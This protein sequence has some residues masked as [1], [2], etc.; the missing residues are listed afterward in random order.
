[1]NR[2][3]EPDDARAP[4]G[5][6]RTLLAGFR[7]GAPEALRE[8]YRMHA[9]EITTM[10]RHGFAFESNA[11][12][13]RFGGLSSPFELQDALH[14]TFARA[15]E[16]AARRAFDGIRPYGPYLRT[17]A[18]NV[19]LRAGRRQRE[20]VPLPDGIEQERAVAGTDDDAGDPERAAQDR[21]LVAVVRAFLDRVAPA[22]R[23]LLQA[24]FVDGLSQRD[25]AEQLGL[26]RQQLRTR[27]ARLREA[28]LDHLRER[29]REGLAAVL[30]SLLTALVVEALR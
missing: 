11:G 21:E 4:C 6:S 26:G 2:T 7:A 23:A 16:P 22:D 5:W 27:E 30:P 14:E 1:M 3:A 20:R 19:V 28:L 13:G 18:R 24:R 29:G 9:R 15:F 10:L 17:I 12:I 25:A 8:I